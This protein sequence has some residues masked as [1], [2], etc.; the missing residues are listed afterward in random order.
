[1]LLHK[2]SLRV[3]M[4]I[5]NRKHVT[6]NFQRLKIMP[7]STLFEYQYVLL[8]LKEVHENRITPKINKNEKTNA[9]FLPQRANNCI[10]ERSLLT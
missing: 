5:E 3:I 10:G 8:F 9:T 2:A 1:M 7:V 4:K 6:A